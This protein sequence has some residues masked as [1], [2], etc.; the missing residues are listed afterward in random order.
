MFDKI[1][2]TSFI[3]KL[4]KNRV[5]ASELKT[6]QKFAPLLK[7]GL[8]SIFTVYQAEILELPGEKVVIGKKVGSSAG[9]EAPEIMN[10][11]TFTKDGEVAII[12]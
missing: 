10:A 1:H 3:D 12:D 4:L 6:G 7:N 2:I 9:S 5:K 8:P 11:S